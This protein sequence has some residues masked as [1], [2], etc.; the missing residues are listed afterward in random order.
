MIRYFGGFA[1]C[2]SKNAY[3]LSSDQIWIRLTLS[4]ANVL[5]PDKAYSLARLLPTIC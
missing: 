2:L 4:G 1:A 3:V 5:K